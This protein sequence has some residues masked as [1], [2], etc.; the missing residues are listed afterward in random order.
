MHVFRPL[1][2][3]MK[4]N[5]MLNRLFDSAR[6]PWKLFMFWPVL[7]FLLSACVANVQYQA[8]V[9]LIPS[10]TVGKIHNEL[11]ELKLP[12]V[13]LYAQLQAF[14]WSGQYLLPPLGLWLN[15]EPHKGP[16]SLTTAKVLLLSDGSQARTVSYLG[17]DSAWFSPRALA[18]GC[19]PRF[20]RTGIGLT[21]FGASQE[22]VL[23][24]DNSLGIFRPSEQPV[25][26]ENTSCFMFWFDT[27]SLPSHN[28]ILKVDGLSSD[29]E[30]IEIPEIQFQ[31]KTLRQFRAFP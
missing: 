29:G 13:T 20:Y 7:A 22:S 14:N 5:I 30:R 17:P 23:S 3:R 26:F 1:S 10:G 18:A 25:S 28:F 15:I 9:P 12:K 21:R 11:I 2:Y 4:G 19:G 16:L 27:D 24:A 31:Q 6:S 8:A